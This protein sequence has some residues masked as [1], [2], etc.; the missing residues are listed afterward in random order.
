MNYVHITPQTISINCPVSICKGC[1]FSKSIIFCVVKI[2]GSLSYAWYNISDHK[3]ISESGFSFFKHFSLFMKIKYL[4]YQIS[5]LAVS[6]SHFEIEFWVTWLGITNFELMET[7]VS[8]P[9]GKVCDIGNVSTCY[10]TCLS[11]EPV[12]VHATS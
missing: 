11:I 1:I 8:L 10:N 9:F 4:K 7:S 6:I 5:L 12:T 2:Y 3:K